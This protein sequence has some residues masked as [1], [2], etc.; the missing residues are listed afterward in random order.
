MSNLLIDQLTQEYGDNDM[1]KMAHEIE[2]LD[3]SRT[4][5]VVG[6]DLYK[7]ACEAESEELAALAIDTYEMGVGMG[8][9]LS[10]TASEDGAIEESL[11]LA[12]N[13][14]KLAS[15][16]AEIGDATG[17][18]MIC[19]MA[20]A[21]IAISNDMQ[22][23]AQELYK[24][25][26]EAEGPKLNSEGYKKMWENRKERAL[27]SEKDKA[28][29][30]FSKYVKRPAKFGYGKEAWSARE[31][32]DIMGATKGDP[33]RVRTTLKA[34]LGTRE[35]LRALSR[36]GIAYGTA[37]AGLYGAKKLYDRNK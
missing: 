36:S 32:R 6:E 30:F 15:V 34:L 12:E 17:D 33:R 21:V 5:V 28:A 16:Y 19:K 37:A 27:A 14:H 3:Q 13:M 31:I 2:A 24:M 1:S 11:E 25:A 8:A 9:C 10:K 18:E 4:L 35:G 26:A 7:L 22:E 23:N 29:G 20:E